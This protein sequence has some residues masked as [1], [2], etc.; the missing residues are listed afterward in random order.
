[1]KL[2]FK[3]SFQAFFIVCAL[4]SLTLIVEAHSGRTDSNGGHYDRS[5][6]SYHYHHGYSAHQHKNGVCPYE[7]DDKTDYGTNSGNID[8]DEKSII[9]TIDLEDDKNSVTFWDVL[10]AMLTQLIPAVGCGLFGAYILSY[11]WLFVFGENKGCL[12]TWISAAVL[13]V[14]AYIWLVYMQ[15]M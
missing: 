15:V 6:G 9:N 8:S 5:D 14:C 4:L 2:F 13:F 1:M 3:K 11:V 10:I 12:I 7:F